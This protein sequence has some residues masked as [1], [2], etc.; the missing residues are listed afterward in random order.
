M[1]NILILNIFLA[2][3]FYPGIINSQFLLNKTV[4]SRT[5]DLNSESI[6]FGDK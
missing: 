6:N 2:V 3:F 1:N 4:V 5:E